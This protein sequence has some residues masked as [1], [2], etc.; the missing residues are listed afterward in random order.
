MS[1]ENKSKKTLWYKIP[2][3]ILGSF[4]AL[5]TVVWGGLN[6]FKYAIYSDFYNVRENLGTIPG[7]NDGFTPQG[8]CVNEENEVY[9]MTGYQKDHT[10]SRIYITNGDDYN[11][12]V[13]LLKEDN[14]PFTQHNGGIATTND[15]VYIS[16][17][18]KIYILD[19]NVLLNKETKTMIMDTY[20]EV[21]NEASFVFSNDEHLYVGEFTGA[22]SYS[23]NHS[24]QTNDGTYNAILTK[25][26]LS[27]LATPLCIYSIRDKVQGMAMNEEGDIVLSTSYGLK[28]SMFYKYDNENITDPKKT[29]EGVPLYYLDNPSKTLKAPPMSEDMDYSNGK[30]ITY[31]E[32]ACDKYVFGK[33]FFATYFYGFTL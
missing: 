5:F 1:K 31:T 4:I 9:L 7:L 18:S 29:F 23:T 10:S 30:W 11:R 12:Y 6:I 28:D 14:T 3:I 27:D 13:L 32:S 25:Y 26:S 19:L 15:K 33:F 2:L 16:T 21:N 22:G 8:I 17:D 20:V 24:I